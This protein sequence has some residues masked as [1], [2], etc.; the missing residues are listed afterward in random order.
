MA[1]LIVEIEQKGLNLYFPLEQ[2]KLTIGRALD[3]D[4]ILSDITVSPHHCEI[5]LSDNQLPVIRNLSDENRLK[6]NRQEVNDSITLDMLPATLE[7]GHVKAQILS[8][9]AP[10]QATRKLKCQSFMSCLLQHPIS[11][12]LIFIALLICE[13]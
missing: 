8:T 10:A 13:A 11:V 12:T 3:N 6:V 4:I 7:L 5:E 1:G 9:D 2:P